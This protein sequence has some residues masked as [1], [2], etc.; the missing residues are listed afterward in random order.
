MTTLVSGV[1]GVLVAQFYQFP[2]GPLESLDAVPTVTI[3]DLQTSLVVLGPTAVGVSL[4]GVGTYTYTWSAPVGVGLYMI[5][6][7][8][9][10]AG[11]PVQASEV[12]IVSAAAMCELEV[13]T[14]CCPDWA[15]YSPAVRANAEAWASYILW[16]LTGR[17]FGACEVTVRPCY[18]RCEP[19]SYETYGVWMDSPYGGGRSYLPFVD[20]LG[21]WRNCGCC[22]IC[23]CGASCEIW[24]PGPIISIQEVTISGVAVDPLTYRVDNAE[25]LVRQGGECWPQCQDFDVA[26]GGEGSLVVTYT[27]GAVLPAA[28]ALAAG[29]LACEFAKACTGADCAIP[30]NV[31]SISRG[32]VNF[33]L[34]TPTD[35]FQNGLTGIE[36]VDRFITSVN[37][38][39]LQA[40]PEVYSL[41]LPE[42]RQQTWP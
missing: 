14:S 40:R 29:A 20:S 15:T 13:D 17:Q 12:F 2:G 6:W 9:L 38:H 25:L 16:A 21:D 27:R 30:E 24:L 8:G 11:N 3:T 23:C 18:R 22:G 34:V 5:V 10:E 35:A 19:R 31:T 26:S 39:H 33:Q 7:N 42:P 36:T 4:A 28:G 1:G 37:P 32:G 41:D